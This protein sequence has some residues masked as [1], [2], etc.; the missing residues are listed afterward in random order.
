V[1]SWDVGVPELCAVLYM[2][3]GLSVVVVSVLFRIMP[4]NP[5]SVFRCGF[6]VSLSWINLP[7]EVV[8][9]ELLATGDALKAIHEISAIIALHELFM[10]VYSPKLVVDFRGPRD[11]GLASQVEAGGQVDAIFHTLVRTASRAW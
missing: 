1:P 9:P 8:K 3:E 7:L 2:I 4:P 10:N 5:S 11:I 6:G